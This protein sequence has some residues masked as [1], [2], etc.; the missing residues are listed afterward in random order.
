LPKSECGT[1]LLPNPAQT[2]SDFATAAMTAGHP[3][4]GFPHLFFARAI[5]SQQSALSQFLSGLLLIANS[6]LLIRGG[7]ERNEGLR[8]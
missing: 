7:L 8:V 6:Q 3:G 5:S 2:T 4:E 1:K